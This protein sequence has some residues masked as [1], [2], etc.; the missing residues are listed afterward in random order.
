MRDY[1]NLNATYMDKYFRRD[2][3]RTLVYSS[4]LQK[5][6]RSMI[7]CLSLGGVHRGRSMRSHL[8]SVSHWWRYN[9]GCRSDTHKQWLR[10][11]DRSTWGNPMMNTPRT[12]W[13]WVKNEDG[14]GWTWKDCPA[15]C[16]GLYKGNCKIQPPF[17]RLLHHR[18]YGF[19]IHTFDC[20]T[21]IMIWMF[22][23]D[24]PY[25]QRDHPYSQGLLS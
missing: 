2:F 1:F 12:S 4:P 6:R 9:L 7:I 23:R 19:D 20:L 3:R 16:K 22:C 13:V 8:W 5:L 10:S 25:S 11:L 15:G 18:I 14:L 24:Q 17:L 21:L